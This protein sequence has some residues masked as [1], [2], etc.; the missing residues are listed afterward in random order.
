M[1][2]KDGGEHDVAIPLSFKGFAQ[3]YDALLKQ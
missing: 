3:A 1:H 2:L